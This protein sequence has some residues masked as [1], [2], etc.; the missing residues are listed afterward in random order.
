VQDVVYMTIC[1]FSDTNANSLHDA[2]FTRCSE[3]SNLSIV[4][5]VQDAA[6]LL[7]K[8][9]AERCLEQG[10]KKVAFDRAGYLYHGKVKTLADSAREAGLVF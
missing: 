5:L 6:T 8:K 10:I 9:I 3:L 1:P 7:G 2:L 4:L